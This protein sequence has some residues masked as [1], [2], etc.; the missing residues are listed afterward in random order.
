M[1]TVR[2]FL[3]EQAEAIRN[4]AFLLGGK[5]ADRRYAQFICD[6]REAPAFTRHLRS[7]LVALHQLLSLENV[8]DPEAPE[9]AFF[10]AIDPADPVVFDICQLTD[11]VY[12]LLVEIGSGDPDQ[13][14]DA[15]RWADS[16]AA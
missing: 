5:P 12:D 13:A 15:P 1:A 14:A 8:S 4:A 11:A 6:V 2:R 3:A 16:E 9:A 10:A 7:E